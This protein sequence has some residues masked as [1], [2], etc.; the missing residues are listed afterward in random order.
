MVLRK[1]GLV[2]VEAKTRSEVQYFKYSEYC[3]RPTTDEAKK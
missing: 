2:V 3:T 1:D